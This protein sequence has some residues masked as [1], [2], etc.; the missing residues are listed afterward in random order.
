MKILEKKLQRD[1]ER[2]LCYASLI[3]SITE[4]KSLAYETKNEYM[5]FV[6]YKPK[7]IAL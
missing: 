4:L 5:S 3:Q 7:I 1:P 6:E 2:F